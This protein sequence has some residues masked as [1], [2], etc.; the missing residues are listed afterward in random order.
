[1]FSFS[2]FFFLW[3]KVKSS[4][5]HKEFCYANINTKHK[6]KCMHT[7]ACCTYDLCTVIWIWFDFF[8]YRFTFPFRH[9]K[10]LHWV[11]MH[12]FEQNTLNVPQG[13]KEPNER[14]NTRHKSIMYVHSMYVNAVITIMTFSNEKCDA[15]NKEIVVGVGDKFCIYFVFCFV[16][17]F[18]IGLAHYQWKKLLSKTR[19]RH[20]TKHKKFAKVFHV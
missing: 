17:C 5:T 9:G 10:Y 4:A 3:W 8:F 12:V 11:C 2:I 20:N 1:M 18:G 14:E 16:F 7:H 6:W 15:E 19:Q 13:I